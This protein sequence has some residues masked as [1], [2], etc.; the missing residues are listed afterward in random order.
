[1]QI[2]KG[3]RVRINK[4]ASDSF[5]KKVEGIVTDIRHGFVHV[6]ADRVIDRWSSDWEDHPGSGCGTSG[7]IIHTEVIG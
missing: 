5:Y 6:L 1:M 2:E 4:M 3:K 7:L